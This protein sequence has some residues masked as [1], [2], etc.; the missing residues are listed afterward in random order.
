MPDHDFH[1][2]RAR[3]VRS[4]YEPYEKFAVNLMFYS[5]LGLLVMEFIDE[6]V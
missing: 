5:S 6:A 2:R 3:I 1:T 4:N